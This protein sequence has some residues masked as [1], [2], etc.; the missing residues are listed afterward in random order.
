MLSQ[1]T[2]VINL[3]INVQSQMVT[4]HKVVETEQSK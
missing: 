4:W 3:L 2:Y 1:V